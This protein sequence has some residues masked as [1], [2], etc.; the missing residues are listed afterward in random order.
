MY[1]KKQSIFYFT[2][3]LSV[4]VFFYACGNNNAAPAEVPKATTKTEVNNIT[5][6]VTT[7]QLLADTTQKKEEAEKEANEKNELNEKEEKK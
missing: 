5:D 7:K 2:C 3:L 1:M 6:T 4:S